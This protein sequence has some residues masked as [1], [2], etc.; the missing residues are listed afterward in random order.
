[1]RTYDMLAAITWSPGFRGILVVAVGVIVLMGSVYLLLATNTGAR[2]GFLL[3]LTGLMGW[4]TIMGL[5]WSMYGIGKQ[6]PA[7]SWKVEEANYDDLT[8]AKLVIARDLPEPEQLPDPEKL[9]EANPKLAEQFPPTEGVKR[10]SLG[11]L[12]GV[13]PDLEDQILTEGDIPDGW[14]LLASSNPQTGEAQASASAYVIDER[15]LFAAQTDFVVL[16]AFSYGGKE[17]RPDDANLLDRVWFKAKRILTWPFGH[18]THYAVVQ[19]QQVV[20]QETE[21]GQ[22]PPLPKADET[23]PV[24][25]VI[26]VRDLGAKRLPSVGVMLFSG[27]VFAVC[28]NSLHRRDKLVAEARAA[29]ARA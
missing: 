24:I 10:P 27:I 15:K 12:L 26:M 17:P 3:A 11:D 7:A 14:T 13:E 18:P 6:G 1:M 5:V 25:S 9:L 21:P 28:C 4:M 22:A 20:P 16:N 19:I 8:Q 29:A 23:K 2:L